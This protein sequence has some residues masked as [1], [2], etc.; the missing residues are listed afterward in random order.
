MLA[1]VVNLSLGSSERF[2]MKYEVLNFE[3]TK[4]IAYLTKKLLNKLIWGELYIIKTIQK[5]LIYPS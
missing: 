1:N 4:A 5:N 3:N 2:N